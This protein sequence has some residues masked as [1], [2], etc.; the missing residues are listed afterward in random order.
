MAHKFCSRPASYWPRFTFFKKSCWRMNIITYMVEAKRERAHFVLIKA[1][2]TDP[3]HTG[4]GVP[5]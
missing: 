2:E 5:E 4:M 3:L 1:Q